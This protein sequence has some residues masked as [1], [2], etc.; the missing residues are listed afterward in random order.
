MWFRNCIGSGALTQLGLK[1]ATLAG[2]GQKHMLHMDCDY[3]S[4]FTCKN[5]D[6]HS[7]SSLSKVL[8]RW[9]TQSD[10]L[11]LCTCWL[12]VFTSA[13]VWPRLRQW[14]LSCFLKNTSWETAAQAVHT[15]TLLSLH[16]KRSPTRSLTGNGHVGGC[17]IKGTSQ[18]M[19]YC[20][21]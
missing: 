14:L 16:S 19:R 12:Q 7:L 21:P 1:E 11:L 5:S 20:R 4:P 8:P 9:Q 17:L 10:H 15:D 13:G 18:E 3:S 6:S 2:D